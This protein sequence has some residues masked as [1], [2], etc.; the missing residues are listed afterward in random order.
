VKLTVSGDTIEVDF[1]G[2]PDQLAQGG[3]NCTLSYTSAHATYPLKCMLTPE[4]RGNAG[5]YRPFGVK[6]PEGSILNAQYPAAVNLRTRTGWYISPG[7]FRAL[8]P[9]LPTRVQAATGL[10]FTSNIYG[11]NAD[12]STFS[13]V[14][15]T[16]A[17]QGA[18]GAQD[19]KNGILWPTSAANTSVEMFEARVPV[20][21]LEKS[22]IP[23]SGGPGEFRGGLAQHVRFRKLS[24]DGLPLLATIYPEG[25]THPAP[26]LFGGG[27]CVA[28]RARVI[29]SSGEVLRDC[30]TGA[31][32][33]ITSTD[34]IVDVVVAGGAGYGNPTARDREAIDRDIALGLVTPEGARRDYGARHAGTGKTT[35]LA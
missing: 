24:D 6:A 17:G 9:A 34:E 29:N 7:I 20:L 5:C 28:A 23:D 27:A 13:D 16:G 15:F 14:L 33:E 21:I 2:A 19:G 1:E 12:G 11:K 3:I 30:G 32:I 31:L 25:V 26:G 10:P 8:A 35:L 18:S 4:V 22:F